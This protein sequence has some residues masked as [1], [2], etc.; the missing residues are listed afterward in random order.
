MGKNKERKLA[1]LTDQ[2]ELDLVSVDA[3]EES[4]AD[5]FSRLANQRLSKAVERMRMIPRLSNKS[6]YDYTPEQV[7]ALIEALTTEVNDIET[8]FSG[9][10]GRALPTL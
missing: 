2:D 8:A 1:L 6:L 4:K 3:G 5:S 9:Q 10:V 7:E